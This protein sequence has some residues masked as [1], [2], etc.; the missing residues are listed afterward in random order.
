VNLKAA[1]RRLGLHYQTAYRL[2]RSGELIAIKVGA[3]YEI[4][5]AAIDRYLAGRHAVAVT[6]AAELERAGTRSIRS[7]GSITDE[8]TTLMSTTTLSTRPVLDL[9]TRHLAETI[10]DFAVVRLLSEDRKWLLGASS[11]HPDP[12]RRGIVAAVL[13]QPQPAESALAQCTL[14]QGRVHRVDFLRVDVARLLLPPAFQQYADLMTVYSLLCVPVLVA[15]RRP[16][17]MIVIARDHPGQP[18]SAAE[19]AEVKAMAVRIA[20][21]VERVE[22][23]TS[24]WNARQ[25]LHDRVEAILADQPDVASDDLAQR[26]APLFDDEVPEAVFDRDRKLIA[27]S[28]AFADRIGLDPHDPPAFTEFTPAACLSAGLGDIWARLIDGDT[29]Y[30]DQVAEGCGEGC[31]IADGV[32]WAVARRPDATPAFVIATCSADLHSTRGPMTDGARCWAVRQ[33]RPAIAV[34]G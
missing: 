19:E 9:V 24:G 13:S 8:L 15:G 25:N 2:V 4:S 12:V 1:A 29:D 28:E 26:L 32:H 21:A 22:R 34:N 3:G 17:G 31:P 27:C 6:A 20:A 7:M 23:F 5:D 18:Y 16:L 30:L 33:A 14:P 11:N 10:G